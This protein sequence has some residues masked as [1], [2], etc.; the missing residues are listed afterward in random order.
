MI[1]T[2]LALAKLSETLYDRDEYI[3]VIT[4]FY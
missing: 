3:I 4:I 2:S 1:E